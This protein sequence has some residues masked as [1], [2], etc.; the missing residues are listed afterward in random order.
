MNVLARLT[1]SG[2]IP[3][4]LISSTEIIITEPFRAGLTLKAI[5][6]TGL[7]RVSQLRNNDTLTMPNGSGGF[8]VVE[9]QVDDDFVQTPGTLVAD[10]RGI[11]ENANDT[12][13]V[14]HGVILSNTTLGNPTGGGDPVF[15]QTWQYPVPGYAGNQPITANTALGTINTVDFRVSAAP[16]VPAASGEIATHTKSWMTNNDTLTVPTYDGLGG[17]ITI[18]FKVDG[19]FVQTPGTLVADCTTIDDT[20]FAL[21]DLV[22]DI[23]FSNSLI[24]VDGGWSDVDIVV[25]HC[26]APFMGTGGNFAL[27]T[28]TATPNAIQ[29]NGMS[30][31]VDELIGPDSRLT[32]NRMGHTEGEWGEID[33]TVL[34]SVHLDQIPP[35]LCASDQVESSLH[36]VPFSV[37]TPTMLLLAMGKA[38]LR[39]YLVGN[40]TPIDIFLDYTMFRQG[41]LSGVDKTID[42]TEHL[43]PLGVPRYLNWDS[44]WA[45]DDGGGLDI[46]PLSGP[47]IY[48]PP[49]YGPAYG[50]IYYDTLVPNGVYT[51]QWWL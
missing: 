17:S 4:S 38:T 49:P 7:P 5:G 50:V 9:M 42:L 12:A 22:W 40:P 35:W 44:I 1:V 29:V 18:E 51:R 8:I 33:P 15:T 16:Q 43:P 39:Y 46:I 14:V 13:T 25:R 28:V 19:T 34:G 37:G 6:Y 2:G 27:T 20:Q 21:R 23:I 24:I 31:G 47:D 30:G 26:A 41:D 10:L 45:Y 3:T 32:A 48:P 11:P 36:L